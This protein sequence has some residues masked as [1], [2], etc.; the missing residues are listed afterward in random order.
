LFNTSLLNNG[1]ERIF[2][3]VVYNG[4][5]SIEALPHN[6]PNTIFLRLLGVAQNRV[7]RALKEVRNVEESF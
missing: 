2:L 5:S 3:A 4:E 6:L 7:H 1:V